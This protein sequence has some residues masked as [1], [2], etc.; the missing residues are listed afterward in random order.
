[1]FKTQKGAV[2]DSSFYLTKSHLNNKLFSLFSGIGLFSHYLSLLQHK[3]PLRRV[4]VTAQMWRQKSDRKKSPQSCELRVGLLD[5]LCRRKKNT[6]C[7][8]SPYGQECRFYAKTKAV[9]LRCQ[10][11]GTTCQRLQPSIL[12]GQGLACS[13]GG[14]APLIIAARGTWTSASATGATARQMVGSGGASS[15]KHKVQRG[16]W[17]KQGQI[18]YVPFLTAVSC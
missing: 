2:L 11:T 1:M 4:Q 7:L 18:C 17:L 14:S 10:W 15:S 16:C 5:V 9:Q 8:A 3:P 13:A 12:E 6:I